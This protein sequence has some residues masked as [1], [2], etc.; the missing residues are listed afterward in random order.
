MDYRTDENYHKAVSARRK[1]NSAIA[2]AAPFV[3]D[4]KAVPEEI[5]KQVK[6][7]MDELS[8]AMEQLK[9]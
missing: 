4:G 9:K 7:T 2:A 1:F 3:A 8:A 5:Q 6:E